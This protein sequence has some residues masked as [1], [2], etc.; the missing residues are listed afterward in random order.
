MIDGNPG[1]TYTNLSHYSINGMM[2]FAVGNTNPAQSAIECNIGITTPLCGL[3]QMPT[4]PG[5]LDATARTNITTW[6]ACGAP[7]N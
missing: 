4:P 1:T 7:N 2:V 5:T 6:L 3:A